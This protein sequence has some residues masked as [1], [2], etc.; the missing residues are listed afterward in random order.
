MCGAR[1]GAIQQDCNTPA[2]VEHQSP[3]AN[4]SDALFAR[5]TLSM[6]LV[7]PPQTAEH[8]AVP[9]EVRLGVNVLPQN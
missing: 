1:E 6:T 7:A 3:K 2:F 9:R 8:A 4:R 5:R